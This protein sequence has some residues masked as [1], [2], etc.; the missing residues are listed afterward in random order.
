MQIIENKALLIKVREPGRITTL[1]PK[2]KQV[3]DHEVLVRW[4]LEES[5]VLKNLKIKNVPSPILARYDWPGLYKPF[6]HQKTT[7]SF[8]TMHR[9]AFCFSEQGCVDSETEYL[10]PTGW[11]KIS[12]YS[13]GEVAQ[14]WPATGAVDFVTPQEYVKLPCD[15]MVRIKTKYGLDQ[16]LSPEHRVLLVDG[17]Q[18]GI[19]QEVTSAAELHRRHDTYHAGCK[20]SI[21]GTRAG[22]KEIAFTGAA[23][24]T[25]FTGTGG[26]GLPLSNPL[27][28]VQVAVIAD[29]YF[30]R[31][32]TRCVVRLKKLRKVERLRKLLQ[33]AKIEYAETYPQYPSAL[34]F[35]VFKFDAPLRVKEFDTQFWSASFEQLRTITDEVLH[36][37]GCVTRGAR[38]SSFVKASADFVQYAFAATGHTARLLT[39]PRERRG[40][41]ETEYVVQIRSAQYLFVRGTKE[42]IKEAPSTDGF[43][44]C[45]MVPSTFL[46]FRRNGCIFL[47]G[48]TGKTSSVIWASDYLLAVGAIRRVLV[49]CPLSIM[50]SAWEADLF[51]FAMH[52]TCAIAHSYSRDKRKQAVSSDAEYVICNYDGLDIIKNEVKCGAFDLIVIDEANAYK[53]VSTRRWK[54]LN[55]IIQ[56][57]TWIWM[58]TGTPAAQSPVDAYGLAKII[59]PSGVPKFFGAFRDLVMTKITQFKYVP[60]KSASSVVHEALQPA[61]RFT[62][63][64]CLDLPDMTY[65]TREV[66]LTAQQHKYYEALRKDMITVAAGE[67]ITAVNAAAGLNKLLQLSAGAVYSDTGDIIAFDATTRMSALL[68]VIEEAS[69]KVIVFAPFRHAIMI[70]A[71][72]LRTQKISC[73]VIHGGI[74]ATKRTEIFSRFQSTP[75]P[76]VL[77]IQPQ[78]AAHGVTLHAANVVVW[79][80]PTTST[81]TYLQ[82]NA[83]VH[84]AGQRNPCTVVHIQG[85]PVEKRIYKML[86]EKMD[87]HTELI[88]L[89]KN[90][91]QNTCNE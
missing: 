34:G 38:Y 89:Y 30:A 60:K 37:D 61:I 71:D 70:I 87:V 50:S 5:Q 15:S 10:S 11:C 74:S 53:T 58:L 23:I 35:H 8:L 13:G 72:E 59:N 68:E 43:K 51:K 90:V 7:A 22:T 12:E 40:R 69:H 63:E 3:G 42:T 6:D 17:K 9:R 45:F 1:I 55:G 79:W 49:L 25:A 24:P 78:A 62:K 29:G 52:R 32:T 88:D 57:D 67:E 4:G 27:L 65:T 86:S 31:N 44:Y 73:D 26:Q 18:K 20:R 84:R 91:L 64:E 75:D 54:T 47:S 28:R 2:S 41:L 77:V 83:R 80:G 33:E 76:H 36:W 56:P 82:A 16:L 81:E 14:Y 46:V 66:P 85:S 39:N 21:G 19:K 48:N